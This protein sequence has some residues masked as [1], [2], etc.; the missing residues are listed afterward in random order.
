KSRRQALHRR[1]G[2]VLRDQ[3]ATIAAAEPELLAHHFT[4]AGLTEA[5]IEWWSTAGQRSL[6]R[7]A[8]VEA[9]AQLQKGLKLV[10]NLPEGVTCMQHELD[11]QVALGKAM[12]ATKGYAAPETSEAFN[13]ARSLCEQLDRPPQLV[14]V[15]HGQWV[16]VLL[17]GDFALARSRA[18]ELL[19]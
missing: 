7:S 5:A 3:F 1:T 16:R 12:I 19:T 8:L 18:E 2:E 15:L 13:R 10:A 11:L 14:S 6:A 17:A 4:Q 9:V